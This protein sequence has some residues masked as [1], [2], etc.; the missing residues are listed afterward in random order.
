[1]QG[2][3]KNRQIV[4]NTNILSLIEKW[5]SVTTSTVKDVII[6][7]SKATPYKKHVNRR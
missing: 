5:A 2:L 4:I 1:M 3:I 7:E 6:I